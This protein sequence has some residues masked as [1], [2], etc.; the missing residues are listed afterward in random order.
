MAGRFLDHDP[1]FGITQL[2]HW[3]DDGTFTIEDVQDVEAIR[4]NAKSRYNSV[5]GSKKWNELGEHV[6]YIPAVFLNKMMRDGSYRDPKAIERFFQENPDFK[7][8]PWDGL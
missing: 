2:F 7:T 1:F 4:D 6:G 5:S 8:R 3:N